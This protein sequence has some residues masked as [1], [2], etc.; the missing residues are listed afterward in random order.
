MTDD[1]SQIC[2]SFKMKQGLRW[3]LKGITV[4]T[5][6]VRG[7][8]MEPTKAPSRLPRQSRL[9]DLRGYDGF[10]LYEYPEL[11]LT[12]AEIKLWDSLNFLPMPQKALSKTFGLTELEK[13]YFPHFFNHK[14]NQTYVNYDPDGMSIKERQEFLWWYQE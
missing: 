3:C 11:E 1:I 7:C 14:E 4:L 6:S 13:G 12:E 2:S 5:N 9:P 8:W 10:L